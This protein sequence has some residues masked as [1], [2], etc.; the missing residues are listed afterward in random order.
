PPR[1][2]PPGRPGASKGH[3][4][5]QAP[6]SGGRVPAGR[7]AGRGLR[8]PRRRRRRGRPGRRRPP[9]PA[10]DHPPGQADRGPPP[11]PPP[12]TPPGPGKRTEPTRTGGPVT[13]TGRV[14]EGV[15][16]GC[17]LLDADDGG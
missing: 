9:H 7:A 4:P 6:P 10:D 14:A 15:E 2:D 17:L 11:P 16:P 12:P 3:D 5:H 1:R 13:V 8:R